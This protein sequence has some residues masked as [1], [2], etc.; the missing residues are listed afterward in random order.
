M[1][2]KGIDERQFRD[3]IAIA[4]GLIINPDGTYLNGQVRVVTID[5][6]VAAK[7]DTNETVGI[8]MFFKENLLLVIIIAIV[9][10][11]LIGLLLFL[12]IRKKKNKKNSEG[13]KNQ[14]NLNENDIQVN[15]IQGTSTSTGQEFIGE[16]D[17]DTLISIKNY[18]DSLN[19][20]F[21]YGVETEQEKKKRFT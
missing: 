6:E 14:Q 8:A 4:A 13:R 20:D 5:K 2:E 19:D 3:A 9:M 21:P 18:F 11:S 12:L 1:Q 15:E 16:E 17:E 10:L 7:E